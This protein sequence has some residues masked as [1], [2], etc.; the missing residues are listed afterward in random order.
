MDRKTEKSMDFFFKWRLLYPL[1]PVSKNRVY[2][3]RGAIFFLAKM[4]QILI[5]PL[6]IQNELNKT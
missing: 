1:D 5:L 2:S 3:V 4:K 6:A